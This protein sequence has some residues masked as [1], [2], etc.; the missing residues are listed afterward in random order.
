MDVDDRLGATLDSGASHGTGT[1]T[2]GTAI[3]ELRQ[4]FVAVYCSAAD[5][6]GDVFVFFKFFQQRCHF[7]TINGGIG[8]A[9]RSFQRGNQPVA[10]FFHALGESKRLTQIHTVSS[11]GGFQRSSS[12]GRVG[13]N[14]G[15]VNIVSLARRNLTIPRAHARRR[16][17]AP[18]SLVLIIDAIE[19]ITTH[20]KLIQKICYDVYITQRFRFHI[21]FR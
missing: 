17:G 6:E 16:K 15:P 5:L 21:C 14:S 9:F 8:Y 11:G 12:C 10:C 3:F 4:R 7:F 2:I 18:Q 13:A 20:I 19:H 1:T